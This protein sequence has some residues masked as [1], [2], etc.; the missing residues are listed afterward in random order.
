MDEERLKRLERIY[1]RIIGGFWLVVMFWLWSSLTFSVGAQIVEE[2]A[3]NRRVPRAPKISLTNQQNVK[4]CHKRLI[5]F[6][7]EFRKHADAINAKVKKNPKL[8]FEQWRDWYAQWSKSLNELGEHYG[9]NGEIPNP[10]KDYIRLKNQYLRIRSVASKFNSQIEE[11]LH[12]ISVDIHELDKE[13]L[14]K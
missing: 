14:H 5:G 11:I 12:T 7:K 8:A 2:V 1:S 10:N 3:R 9:F 4:D 6:Y 13:L